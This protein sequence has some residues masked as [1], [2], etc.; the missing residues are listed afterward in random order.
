[1]Q[2]MPQ[3]CPPLPDRRTLDAIQRRGLV[4]GDYPYF[5]RVRFRVARAGVSPAYSYTLA[6]GTVVRAFSYGQNQNM[7]GAGFT[8]VTS[9]AADTNILKAYTS[10]AAEDL[11]IYGVSLVVNPN[12]DF[13]FLR[14][15]A[16]EISVRIG[17]NGEDSTKKLGTIVNLP[18]IGGLAGWGNT[19]VRT[20]PLD[21]E[22]T[23][24]F[25]GTNGV[26]HA[27]DFYP[28]PSGIFW[29]KES[30]P[31]GSLVV[32]LTAERAVVITPL[33]DRVA[34][35][36]VAAYNPPA[37]IDLDFVVHLKARS[38]ASQSVNR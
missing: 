2:R 22:R 38:L 33:A 18:S 11:A 1:M 19:Q 21:E 7:D 3:N 35:A 12:S 20:P 30:D 4:E 5:S 25:L 8:G 34:A 26:P 27:A 32:T 6:A 15:S 10:L 24:A 9:T 28:V 37:T 36:G 16:P 23:Y 29:R 31:D 14:V 17:V 13:E